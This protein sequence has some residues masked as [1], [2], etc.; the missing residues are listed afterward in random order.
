[1]PLYKELF[2]ENLI[3]ITTSPYSHPI[4]PLIIDTDI[5]KRC[6]ENNLPQDKFLIQ[7]IFMNR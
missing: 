3:K 7:K 2:N 1:L 5:A 6:G 4:I